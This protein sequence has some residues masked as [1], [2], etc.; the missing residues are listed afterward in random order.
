MVVSNRSLLKGAAMIVHIDK[1]FRAGLMTRLLCAAALAVASVCAVGAE[2]PASAPHGRRKLPALGRHEKMRFFFTQWWHFRKGGV[3][4]EELMASLAK[5]GATVFVDGAYRPKRAE[6]A[7][8]NGIRYFGGF[9]TAKLRG[10]A[11]KLKSRLAVNLEG[12]TCPQRFAEWGYSLDSSA[13]KM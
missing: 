5:V 12:K 2:P 6:L 10:P 13:H 1:T 9:G 7:H 11:E 8:A 3:S 4:D